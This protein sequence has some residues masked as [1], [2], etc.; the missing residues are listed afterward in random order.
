MDR[1]CKPATHHSSF[2]RILQV[3]MSCKR[4]CKEFLQA[5]LLNTSSQTVQG[6]TQRQ[7]QQQRKLSGQA[8]C[9]RAGCPNIALAAL[10][11][12]VSSSYEHLAAAL[13]RLIAAVSYKTK[14][15]VAGNQQPQ[16]FDAAGTPTQRQLVSHVVV[17][18]Q[19]HVSVCEGACVGV[20]PLQTHSM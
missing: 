18:P 10:H 6:T 1:A 13:C 2:T 9:K 5:R 8:G 20:H 3:S 17:V 4:S 11:T 19:P 15:T 7:Q 16:A 14:L 12:L